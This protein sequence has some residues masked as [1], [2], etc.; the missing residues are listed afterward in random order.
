MFAYKKPKDGPEMAARKLN[1][2][3]KRAVAIHEAG[4]Y[5][6]GYLLNKEGLYFRKPA[7][8][9]II[10]RYS[11]LGVVSLQYDEKCG[12]AMRPLYSQEFEI[13]FKIKI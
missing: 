5:L 1:T 7:M 9:T 8:A 12:P 3:A 10:G 13:I 11:Y 6:V 4:H 2:A